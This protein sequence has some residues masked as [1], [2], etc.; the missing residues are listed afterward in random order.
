MFCATT[1][2]TPHIAGCDVKS[3]RLPADQAA[4]FVSL[5]SAADPGTGPDIWLSADVSV[6]QL[7]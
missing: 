4:R 5:I 2:M 6:L 3:P 7:L 1:N